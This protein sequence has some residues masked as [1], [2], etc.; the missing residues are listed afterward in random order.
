MANN[1]HAARDSQPALVDRP[2]NVADGVPDEAETGTDEVGPTAIPVAVD[3]QLSADGRFRWSAA[4]GA[5]VP[6]GKEETVEAGPLEWGPLMPERIHPRGC[7]CL[8]CWDTG[9][10]YGDYLK[11]KRIRDVSF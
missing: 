3:G 4:W 5:W 7:W 11:A 6:T 8:R 1:L 2:E 10:R 9:L